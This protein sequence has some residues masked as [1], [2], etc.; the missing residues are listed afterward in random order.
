[1]AQAERSRRDVGRAFTRR[2]MLGLSTVAA[3]LAAAAAGCGRSGRAADASASSAGR[4]TAPSADGVLAADLNQ[5]LDTTNYAELP[6]LSATWIRGFY[7]VQDADHGSVADQ[8]GMRKFLA[9]AGQGYGSVLN[10]KFKYEATAGSTSTTSSPGCAPTRRSWPRSSPW[11]N[12]TSNTSPIRYPRRSP[13]GTAYRAAARCGRSSAMR[14]STPF[15]RPSGT[16]SSWPA[17]GSRT[18]SSS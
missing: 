8:A 13:T 14:S 10:L 6:N 18:P 15:R 4:V 2:R 16:T 9:A 3:G 7:P 5:N 1:M 17:R 12:S 11:S